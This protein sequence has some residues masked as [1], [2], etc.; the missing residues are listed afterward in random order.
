MGVLTGQEVVTYWRIYVDVD[1]DGNIRENLAGEYVVP[2]REYDFYF[3]K[4]KSIG[5]NILDYKVEIVKF[6][7]DL[8]LKEVPIEEPTETAPEQEPTTETEPTT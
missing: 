7:P 4:E 1:A 6:K 8:V 3:Y 2:D 5:E